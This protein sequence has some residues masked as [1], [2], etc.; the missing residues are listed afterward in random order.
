[1]SHGIQV[2][3]YDEQICHPIP[4]PQG[5]IYCSF[6]IGGEH[7][8]HFRALKAATGM[9]SQQLIEDALSMMVALFLSNQGVDGDPENR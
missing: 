2:Q 4:W 1:M 6:Y 8:K 7:L 5:G 9:S 3:A